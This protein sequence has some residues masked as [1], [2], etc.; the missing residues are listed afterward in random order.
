MR[1]GVLLINKPSDWTS[2]DIV[3]KLRGILKERRIGHGG[4]LDPMATGLLMIL[5]GKAT[6]LMDYLP[7]R[8]T[9]IAGLLP[10]YTSNTLDITGELVKTG[11]PMPS[12]K[13]IETV[14]PKFTGNYLQIPPMVSALSVNG[15]RLYKIARDGGE[16]ERTP[17]AVTVYD[18]AVRKN[19]EAFELDVTCSSG[20]YIR[21]LIDDIGRAVGCGAVMSALT[22]TAIGEFTLENAVRITEATPNNALS[23]C[24][25][26]PSAKHVSLTEDLLKLLFCG[27]SIPLKDEDGL[28][29]VFA[30]DG[31]IFSLARVS[32]GLIKNEVF[33]AGD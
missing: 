5:I 7:N 31:L 19:G 28:Y 2:H 20:T 3:A 8:K 29:W 18:I 11:A 4:T 30:E 32:D 21:S 6:K 9:Y 27:Q 33:L 14:L 1:P 25:I 22:R 13:D 10:G 23:V 17:R 24:D 12:L 26:L 15:K 16:V